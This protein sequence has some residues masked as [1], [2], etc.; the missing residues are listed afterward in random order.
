M[1]LRPLS[2]FFLLNISV[3]FSAEKKSQKFTIFAEKNFGQG[4]LFL[5]KFGDDRQTMAV[6]RGGGDY[7][8]INRKRGQ[9]R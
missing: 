3:K 9:D 4:K 7:L 1:N 8:K 5:Y 2:I 6:T